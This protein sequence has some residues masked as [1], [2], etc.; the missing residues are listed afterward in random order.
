MNKFKIRTLIAGL[1]MTIW[2]AP[3]CAEPFDLAARP[4]KLHTEDETISTVGALQ[5]LGGIELRSRHPNFGGLSGMNVSKNGK[6][7]SLVTDKGWWVTLQPI[8][9]QRGYLV[10]ARN[11]QIG[12]LLTPSGKPISDSGSGD[13]E[14]IARHGDAFVVSFESD[15]KMYLYPP[16]E[17]PL[18]LKPRALRLPSALKGAPSNGQIEALTML[19][20][21]R[22][23]A[24]TEKFAHGE[25]AVIGWI[26][27]NRAWRQIVYQ[28][29]GKFFPTGAATLP[30]GDVILLERRF[31][32]LAGV[33]SRIVRI[34]TS[35]ILPGA[36][37]RGSEIAVL[38]PPFIVE[39]FEAIDIRTGPKGETLIYILSDD[40]F[41]SIQRNLLLLFQL[42]K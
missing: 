7:L 22:L 33:A 15:R 29:S 37:I 25:K 1:L 36:R 17:N 23:F 34:S 35:K 8:H 40:N 26:T 39:N 3:L 13:G 19:K 32:W 9:D 4:V 30:D 2:T 5:F 41:Q 6:R 20:G 21:G 16:G 31:N 18:A 24:L 27:Q 42:K 14:A 38:E 12:K 11:G 28:R 10:D